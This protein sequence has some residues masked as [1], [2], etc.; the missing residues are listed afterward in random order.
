[1]K[2]I[3]VILSGG[4]GSRLWPLSRKT[5][6]KQLLPLVSKKT[7]LQETIL[8]LKDCLD[9]ERPI[10]ICGHDHRFIV[11]EQLRDIKIKARLIILEPEGRNTAPAIATA[12]LS[13]KKKN[14]SLLVLPADHIIKDKNSFIKSIQ[15]AQSLSEKNKLVTF[16][17]KPDN[18]DVGYGYIHLGKS[19][20][21]N[22]NSFEI[23]RF[24][25]KPNLSLAKKYLDSGEYLWNSGMFMFKAKV[26]LDELKKFEPL[27]FKQSKLSLDKSYN[28]LDFLRL[29]ENEFKLCPSNSIDYAL[30][31]KTKLGVIVKTDIGW[32]D[33][34]SWSSL[35]SILKNDVN[36]MF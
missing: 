4:S 6:P 24:V 31:E 36:I 11:A 35:S 27:I 23:S 30:M 7:M 9:I 2:I 28:D 22:Q 29:E 25:E 32:S 10:I 3:P 21:K 34:G 33:I 15:V 17:I 16:G 26:Y 19:L 12:A 1:M 13:L 5:L 8:R 18:P 14:Y 20:S